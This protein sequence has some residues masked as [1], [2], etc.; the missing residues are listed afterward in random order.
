[1]HKEVGMKEQTAV[2]E[3]LVKCKPLTYL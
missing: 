2:E 1:M 3:V